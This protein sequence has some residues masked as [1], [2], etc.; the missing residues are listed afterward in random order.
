MT[1]SAGAPTMYVPTMDAFI[2]R[3]F[4]R[5]EDARKSLETEGGFLFPFNDQFFVTESEAL[6]ELGMDPGDPDWERIGHDWVRPLDAEAM[7]RLLEKR[8]SAGL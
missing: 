5:Y 3:W 8:L 6:R 4:A 2:N 7:Q 1:G